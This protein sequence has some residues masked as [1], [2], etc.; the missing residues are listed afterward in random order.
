MKRFFDVAAVLLTAPVSVPIVIIAAVALALELRGNPFFVQERVGLR[1]ERFLM[2]KL[3]TM[4]HA[5][6]TEL[7]LY[8]VGNWDTYVFAP[9]DR[10]DPRITRLGAFARKTSIDE[11]PNLWN[12]FR[13]EMSLVGPRPEI[14]A[15]VEQYPVAY[16][17]RHEVLPGIAGLAQVEGRSDLAYAEVMKYDLAYVDTRSFLGDLRILLKTVAVVARGSGAR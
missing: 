13:G 12:V 7:S 8:E 6:A 17:R 3:R 1:G 11:L 5:S 16:H 4:R 14:P 9:P 10:P 15:L 2:F